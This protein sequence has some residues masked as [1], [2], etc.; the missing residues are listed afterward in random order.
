MCL[1]L[2]SVGTDFL[3][4]PWSEQV[5]LSIEAWNETAGLVLRCVYAMH[6]QVSNECKVMSNR[7]KPRQSRLDLFRLLTNCLKSIPGFKQTSWIVNQKTGFF[8]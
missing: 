7:N 5:I 4:F 3:H 1:G 2:C 6:T 8:A